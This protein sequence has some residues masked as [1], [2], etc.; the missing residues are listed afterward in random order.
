M[1]RDERVDLDAD[2]DADL[3]GLGV[4][5]PSSWGCAMLG[6][7]CAA[8]CGEQ[9]GVAVVAAEALSLRSTSPLG[10]SV[11]FMGEELADANADADAD[12]KP[13]AGAGHD[14]DV[15]DDK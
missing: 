3:A 11:K 9:R 14:A 5:E 2:A 1:L 6:F 13:D 10:C 12:A 4:R 7:E 15:D 8:D